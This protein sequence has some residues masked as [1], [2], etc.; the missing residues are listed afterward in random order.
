MTTAYFLLG[1]IPRYLW[2]PGDARISLLQHTS[3]TSRPK[4]EELAAAESSVSSSSSVV[5]AEALTYALS[6]L[7]K[8]EFLLKEEQK[9][10]IYS[11]FSGRD[12]FVWLP[13]GFR[14]SICFQML[15]FMF[16]RRHTWLGSISNTIKQKRLKFC[17][18]S[19]DVEGV[20]NWRAKRAPH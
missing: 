18:G 9:L 7:G 14:K 20:T 4:W 19:C 8:S 15:P 10:A 5:S 6:K 17:I 11:L 12:V 2:A 13:T 3:M 16:D 1:L